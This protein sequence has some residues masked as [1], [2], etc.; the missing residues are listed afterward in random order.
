MDYITLQELKTRGD[1]AELY[2]T[3]MDMIRDIRS[4]LI[5]YEQ[6]INN[7][8][9]EAENLYVVSEANINAALDGLR[10]AN[11]TLEIYK[12]KG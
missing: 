11:N 12:H 6:H 4:Q 3:A 9:E 2:N 5:H 8:L 7:S 10:T 1:L